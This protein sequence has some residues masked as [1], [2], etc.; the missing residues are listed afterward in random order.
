MQIVS[1]HIHHLNMKSI[2]LLTFLII[3]G[4]NNQ[5]VAKSKIVGNWSH[6]KVSY[7][8]GIVI[9]EDYDLEIIRNGNDDYD[10]VLKVITDDKSTSSPGKESTYTGDMIEPIDNYKWKFS[11]GHFGRREAY[12]N[13]PASNWSTGTPN[14]LV[15]SFDDRVGESLIFKRS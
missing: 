8:A 9:I 13:I 15:I 14:E 3:A 5:K 10:Y 7:F 6:L 1:I 4:C 11:E 12:I 2:Y